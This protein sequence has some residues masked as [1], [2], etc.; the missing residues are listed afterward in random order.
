MAP[1]LCVVTLYLPADNYR[2]RLT[3]TYETTSNWFVVITVKQLSPPATMFSLPGDSATDYSAI[4]A[5]GSTSGGK[6]TASIT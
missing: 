3:A 5:D 6:I 2:N 1:S 4:S